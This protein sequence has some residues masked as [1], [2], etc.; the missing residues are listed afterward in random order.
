MYTLPH[1]V[2]FLTERWLEAAREHLSGRK[3]KRR[4]LPPP[5]TKVKRKAFSV[6]GRFTDAPPHLELPG[7]AGAFTLR[8]DGETFLATNAFDPSADQVVEGDYQAA[9]TGAQ[10]VGITAPGAVETL[11]REVAHLYGPEALKVRCAIADPA[12]LGVLGLLFDDLGRM[13]VENPDLAH[14]AAKQGLTG[15]I[16][17]MDETGYTIVEN[18][19]TPEF[20]DAAREHILETLATHGYSTMNWMLYHGRALERLAL[21]PLLLTLI[22]ASLGRGAVIGSLSCIRKPAGPG[23]IPLHTD[24]AHVPEP[25]P[26]WAMTG[27]GVWSFEDWTQESGPTVLL[28][29]SHRM[30]RYPQ[31]G[32]DPGAGV[33]ILMPKGSVVFFTE[34]VWHWQG[35]RTAPGERV[36]LH[37]HFNRGIL[38]SL[39]ARKI[40]EQMIFRNPPRLGEMLG[41]DDWFEKTTGEGRDYERY[42]Y[43]TRLLAFTE[44]QKRAMLR[45][46][47]VAATARPAAVT[48]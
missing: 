43:M 4:G 10:M 28:P 1:H 30:R 13:T 25:Y 17:E 32:E 45:E 20:A 14:R 41:Q 15:K 35:D 22:D 40:D 18:A 3:L 2:E 5:A 26:E 12:V 38:R 33:P 47:N 42:A 29:G 39:E 46:S 31:K 23:F 6:S 11:L 44:A 34:G 24:Y 37:S 7:N 48:A 9:L 36:T 21:N 8:F 16:R 27:V 19:I